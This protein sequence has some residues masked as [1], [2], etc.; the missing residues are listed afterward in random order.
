MFETLKPGGGGAF[1][2]GGLSLAPP[3]PTPPSP[4]TGAGDDEA[5]DLGKVDVALH[6]RN[7][8]A[9]AVWVGWG[10]K[11]KTVESI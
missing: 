10:G 3:P 8:G 9:A 7:V 4:H 1:K 2:A 11:F 5:L 6:R